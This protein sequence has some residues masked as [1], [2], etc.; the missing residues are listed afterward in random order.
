MLGLIVKRLIDGLITLWVVLTLTFVMIRLLPGGPFQ[1]PRV[2]PA[3]QRNLEARYHLN[4]PVMVQYGYYLATLVQGDLGPSYTSENRTVNDIVSEATSISLMI[5]LPALLVGAVGGLMLGT[6][7]GL[8]RLRWLDGLLS[9]CGMTALS[10]PTFVFAGVLVLIFAL[11][12]NW[13]PAATLQTP[14]HFVLPVLSLSLMPF[15]F[16][17]L[18]IRST[19]AETRLQTHVH[20]KRSFGLPENRI[21]VWHVLRNSL[22]PLIS[23]LGPIAAAVI[24]GSFAV[25]TIFAVPGL[26][27]YFVSAVINRD[28]T[29]VMGITIVYSVALI[30]FNTLTELV[31]GWLD[32]RLRDAPK[33]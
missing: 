7:A 9:V 27:R 11:W 17:F 30:V 16:T 10:F 5:G 24:T 26:G 23:I 22:L 8:T 6:V 4:E 12:L 29:V 21:A 13:L 33:G 20:I 32:P 19:V 14:A 18:L 3:I 2:P 31:Y 28:Y 15:A 1:N 25:E